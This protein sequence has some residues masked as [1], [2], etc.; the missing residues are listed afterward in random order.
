MIKTNSPLVCPQ[1]WHKK[2]KTAKIMKK[3][4]GHTR[5]EFALIALLHCPDQP[6]VLRGDAKE[7]N[8][9]HELNTL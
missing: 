4:K 3:H 2:P 7:I 5:D 6:M 9:A 8:N 1:W